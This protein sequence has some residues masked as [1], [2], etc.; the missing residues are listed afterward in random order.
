MRISPKTVMA[1]LNTRNGRLLTDQ[2]AER[3][4][5]LEQTKRDF[6]KSSHLG[7]E[8][9]QLK[10]LS[11]TSEPD[12][13]QQLK[14]PETRVQFS[15]NGQALIPSPAEAI[16]L[17]FQEKSKALG[18]LDTNDERLG[19]MFI[20]FKN[21]V[22]VAL[23]KTELDLSRREERY[24]FEPHEQEAFKNGDIAVDAVRR[25]LVQTTGSQ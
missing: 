15:P 19:A 1:Y 13:I 16:S 25:K 2:A 17:R 21:D 4:Y 10:N 9:N 14:F 6:N 23:S 11:R 3:A 8:Q 18:W 20:E 5:N 12:F 24:L 22:N 7:S